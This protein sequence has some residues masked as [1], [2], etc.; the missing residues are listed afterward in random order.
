MVRRARP[1]LERLA[2]ETGEAANLA[3]REGRF[4]L[5][6]VDQVDPPQIMAPNWF[7]RPV[8]LHA[9]STGKAY[10]AFLDAGRASAALPA[11]LERFT[12][13]TIT[14]RKRLD[15]ELDA[16]RRNGFAVC[17]GE[18]EE[19]LFGA[20]APVL[21][22]AG[23]AGGDRQRLGPRAPLPGGAARR[24]RPAGA[25]GGG[26]DQG[27]PAMSRVARRDEPRGDVCVVASTRREAERDL[28]RGRARAAA[29]LESRAVQTSGW[30]SSSGA[31]RAFSA[32]ADISEFADRDPEAILAYYRETGNVYEALAALPQPTIS[33]I[34]GYCLGGGLE[35]ALATDFR[36]ADETAGSGSPRSVSASCPAPAARSARAAARRRAGE[37]ADPARRPAR[38]AARRSAPGSSPKSSPGAALERALELGQQ[39]R[40]AAGRRRRRREAGDRRGRM[41]RARRRC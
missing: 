7:G 19:S 15:A 38:R 23:Q 41:P 5:V 1:V 36:I 28:D 37:A 35:L 11:R 39:A 33:A 2:R 29:A 34:H 40:S 14:D 17:L 4:N 30:S 9:T 31:G 10:L 32:G 3:R 26:R 18:L 21:S 24:K 27:A 13:T 8:P 20:S 12:S 25:R 16:A 22:R 6:Y